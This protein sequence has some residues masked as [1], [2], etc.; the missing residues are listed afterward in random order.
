MRELEP[1]E[2]IF[3]AHLTFLQKVFLLLGWHVQIRVYGPF[4]EWTVTRK[5]MTGLAERFE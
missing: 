2:M 5:P 4:A 3:N 1:N